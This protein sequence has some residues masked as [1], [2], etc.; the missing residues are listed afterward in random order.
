M[1]PKVAVKLHVPEKLGHTVLLGKQRGKDKCCKANK[2][3][4]SCINLR[5]Y[6]HTKLSCKVDLA[7][8]NL[9]CPKR[10][11]TKINEHNT[12]EKTQ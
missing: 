10:S 6:L 11:L 9:G 3:T 1:H 7:T 12:Q 4:K 8:T 2:V 5:I